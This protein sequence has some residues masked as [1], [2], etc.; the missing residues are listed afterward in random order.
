M[1]IRM[2]IIVP[3]RAPEYVTFDAELLLERDANGELQFGFYSATHGA[4][5]VIRR[6]DEDDLFNA[7]AD[8]AVACVE[9]PSDR[10]NVID[11]SAARARRAATGRVRL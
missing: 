6:E 4:V 11:F 10:R 2:T 5:A 3:G 8:G 1:N 7:I 9:L